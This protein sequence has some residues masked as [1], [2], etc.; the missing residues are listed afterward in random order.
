ME[1][2]VVPCQYIAS[3]LGE[4]PVVVLRNSG[5]EGLCQSGSLGWDALFLGVSMAEALCGS[6]GDRV[7]AAYL[8]RVDVSLLVFGQ[9]LRIVIDAAIY[10]ER[11]YIDERCHMAVLGI[12]Q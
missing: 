1:Y 4:D 2:D 5:T 11:R 6:L 3:K 7:A 12:F 8:H 9:W 10:F